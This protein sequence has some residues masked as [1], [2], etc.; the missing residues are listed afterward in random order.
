MTDDRIRYDVLAQDAL[1]G[2]I[3][4][5][6]TRVAKSGLPGQHH[7]YISFD[8]QA[9]GAY[10]SKRLRQQYPEEMTIVLQYQ[11]W[12]LLV[13]EDR[14]E[15]KLSFNNVPERLVVPFAAVKAFF[16]PSVQFGLQFGAQGPANDQARAEGSRPLANIVKPT[17]EGLSPLAGR[18]EIAALAGRDE[19]AETPP[20]EPVEQP[21][22]PAAD[23]VELDAFRNKK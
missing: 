10:L 22:R 1:R 4:T 14:F 16:D 15:V 21:N 9:P 18:D 7:L 8:T 2:V 19:P 6:L 5:V 12:D 3:R 20:P 23:V 11:F 17:G 13:S